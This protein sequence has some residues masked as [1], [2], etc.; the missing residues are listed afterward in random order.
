MGIVATLLRPETVAAGIEIKKKDGFYIAEVT[1]SEANREELSAAFAQRELDIELE[2]VPV[3]PS[4]VGTIVAMGDEGGQGIET[5]SDDDRCFTGGGA[6]PIG[7]RVPVDY[8]GRAE[9]TI[10]RSAEPGENYASTTDPFAPA[11]AL[12]CIDLYGATIEEAVAELEP[13]GF[14]VATLALVERDG[15]QFAEDVEPAQ[16]ATWYVQDVNMISANEVV[17]HAS[18]E[19]VPLPPDSYLRRIRQGC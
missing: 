12:R 2:L 3:S 15:R 7:L 11:E 9:I 5:L 8:A 16:V 1:D 14:S 18:R 13:R 17:I 19:A 6:C 4:L 10:S